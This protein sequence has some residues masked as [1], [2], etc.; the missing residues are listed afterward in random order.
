LAF[1]IGRHSLLSA[2][3]RATLALGREKMVAVCSALATAT[4]CR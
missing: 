4:S 2:C 3:E 1:L